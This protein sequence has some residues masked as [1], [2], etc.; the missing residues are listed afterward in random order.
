MTS[1]RPLL[2]D[3]LFPALIFM[4]FLG[5]CTPPPAGAPSTALK[6]QLQQLLQQQS[7]QTEQIQNL[8]QQLA[9]LQQQITGE[10]QVSA[11]IEART[12]VP[13]YAPLPAP[14]IPAAASQEITALTASA[15]S[16]LAAFTDLASGRYAAAET[17]F[18]NFLNN[19]PE[20]QY[21][22]NARYWLA[23]AQFAQGKLQQAATNLR[24]ILNDPKGQAKAPA[25][26]LQLSRIYRQQGQNPQADEIIEQL[27]T[28]YPDSPEAQ[29]FYR[30]ETPTP[31]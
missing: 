30:S 13:K 2:T 20:H 8:Q 5:A 15:S 4:T 11:Q 19:Y 22:A 25:A 14:E 1:L 10:A 9:Q 7:Q 18:Q 26:L 12:E 31:K 17:G 23:K 16:Y 29:H 28:S 3:R 6:E 21:T 27:R 24:Q